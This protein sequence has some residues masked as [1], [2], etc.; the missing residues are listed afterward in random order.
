MRIAREFRW[1]MSR[2]V[3]VSMVVQ[4]ALL[5]SLIVGN[6]VDGQRRMDRLG[7]DMTRVIEQVRQI[8]ERMDGVN[9]RTISHEYRLRAVEEKGR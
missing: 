5:A 6:W 7:Y 2:Q 8:G 9:E 1:R 4:V 3:N